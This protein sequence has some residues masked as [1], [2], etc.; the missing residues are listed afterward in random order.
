M[1]KLS[2]GNSAIQNST[3]FQN[4]VNFHYTKIQKLSYHALFKMNA[5]CICAHQLSWVAHLPRSCKR[6]WRSI[7]LCKQ[8]VIQKIPRKIVSVP[9]RGTPKFLTFKL[10]IIKMILVMKTILSKL[11]YGYFKQKYLFE[12]QKLLKESFIW[13]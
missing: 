12:N 3:K 6:K 7:K 4:L 9:R 8:K 5:F 11:P 13:I 1:R 2:I 10:H